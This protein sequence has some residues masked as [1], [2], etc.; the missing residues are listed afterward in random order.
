MDEFIYRDKYIIIEQLN[1]NFINGTKNIL[2]SISCIG[3]NAKNNV[4]KCL[5]FFQKVFPSDLYR[6]INV[7]GSNQGMLNCYH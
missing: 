2:Y 1:C 3:L 4:S 6:I 5:F 7:C